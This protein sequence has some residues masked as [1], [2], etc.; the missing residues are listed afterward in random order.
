MPDLRT[1][2]SGLAQ[3]VGKFGTV[4]AIAYVVDVGLFNVLRFGAELGP[5]TSKT[6][7]TLAAVT[8]AYIGNRYWTWRHR[9]R[10]GFRREYAMFA[11][12][13][14]GG[15]VIQ[16]TCLGFTVYVL[17]LDGRVAENI[18]GN[19]VGVALGTLFRFWAYR[20]WVFPQL[21]PPDQTDEALERTTTTPY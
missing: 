10:Y 6:I 16:L 2:L 19:V 7:S 18:A 17:G 15:L 14:G 4:G 8:V 1:R 5:L 12:V 9:R 3:E 21:P 13:N 11:L 20:T